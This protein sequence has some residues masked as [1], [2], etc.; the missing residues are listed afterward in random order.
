MFLYVVKNLIWWLLFPAITKS[1]GVCLVSGHVKFKGLLK[2]SW[3]LFLAPRSA[4]WFVSKDLAQNFRNREK[5]IET[6]FL[7]T[8]AYQGW[9]CGLPE[10]IGKKKLQYL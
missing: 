9:G 3:Q 7:E 6:K 8:L 10:G 2:F 4:Y 5:S 1:C